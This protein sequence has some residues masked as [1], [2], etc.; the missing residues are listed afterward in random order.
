MAPAATVITRLAPRPSM[1]VVLAP[2]LWFPPNPT[3]NTMSL[4]ST[5]GPSVSLY[6]P[7]GSS[8][9]WPALVSATAIASR[10]VQSFVHSPSLPSFVVVTVT[11]P[12][13]VCGRRGPG[14]DDKRQRRA[15]DRRHPK[16]NSTS[17]A[18]VRADGLC[19]HRSCQV[20]LD[21]W[22]GARDHFA[23]AM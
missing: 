7:G 21:R 20:R 3:P 11:F 19:R 2:A 1:I 16:P 5:S 18:Q 4:P 6:T 10:R 9:N 22:T 12:N 13:G 8:T 14:H 15:D 17:S 23:R